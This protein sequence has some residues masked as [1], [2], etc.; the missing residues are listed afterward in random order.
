MGYALPMTL[1]LVC[2]YGEQGNTLQLRIVGVIVRQAAGT[3]KCD[4]IFPLSG[5]IL[6]N[7]GKYVQQQFVTLNGL[8]RLSPN[9]GQ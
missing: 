4:L 7:Q 8:S 1:H 2:L 9:Q 6:G 5:L 3:D